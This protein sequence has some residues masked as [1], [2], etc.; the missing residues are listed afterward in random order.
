VIAAKRR[1]IPVFHMEAGN[2][3]FDERVPEELN[4]RLVDHAA[5]INLP[6]SEHARQYLLREGI[7]PDTVIRTGSPMREVLGHYAPKIEAS[8]VL[9][10][11]G[12]EVGDYFLVS[13]HREENIDSP[14]HLAR[15]IASLEA[16]VRRYRK[17]TIVSTHPR[18]RKKLATLGRKA[19]PRGV[20]FLKPLGF[21]DYVKLQTQ[22][23]CVLSDSGTLT[24][25]SSILAFPAV[26]LREAHERPEGMDEA[27]VVMSGLEPER[28]LA[29]V[30][31]TIAHYRD[32]ERPFRMAPDYEADNVSRK[33]V[34]VILSYIDYVNRTVWRQP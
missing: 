1:K 23:R 20:E 17:R 30:E 33:V 7:R 24:E 29:A 27:A 32:A 14:A 4:R 28:V 19:V 10:R 9:G 8:R 15:L 25:E 21:I 12:L 11:L 22:A 5:D 26:M 18:T 34:R 31:L 2:R 16:I 13:A 3:C 6:Y